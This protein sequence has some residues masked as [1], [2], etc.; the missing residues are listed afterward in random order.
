MKQLVKHL[1]EN[2]FDEIL[3]KSLLNCHCVGLHSIMLLESPGK[4]IRLF[5]AE[6]GNLMYTNYADSNLESREDMSICFHAHHCDVTLHCIKGIFLNWIIEESE[7]KDAFW[8]RKFVYN[9]KITKGEI[10]FGEV[11]RTKVRTKKVTN[12]YSGETIY[13]KANELHTVACS[14]TL[15]T[16]W[17]VYEGSE[18]KNYKSLCYSKAD[19]NSQNFNMLYHKPSKEQIHALIEKSGILNQ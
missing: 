3:S 10:K 7:A 11:G 2:N 17:L 1:L 16:A 13:M 19:L 9:S 5:I 18:D 15:Y 8:L 14:K 6:P 12:V 4:T